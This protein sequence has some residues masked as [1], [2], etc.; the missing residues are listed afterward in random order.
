MKD[1]L[2]PMFV[3]GFIIFSLYLYTLLTAISNAHKD[4]KKAR[5]E[6]PEMENFNWKNYEKEHQKNN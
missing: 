6:D 5:K 4:Q 2:I 3:I 1:N